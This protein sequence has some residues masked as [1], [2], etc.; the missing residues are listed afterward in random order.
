MN[1]H[2]LFSKKRSIGAMIFFKKKSAAGHFEIYSHFITPRPSH[3]SC[4]GL[5]IDFFRR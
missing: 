3:G 4:L 5:S 1:R 2:A